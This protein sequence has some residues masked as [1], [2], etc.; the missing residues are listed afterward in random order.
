[1]CAHHLPSTRR[2]RIAFLIGML[3]MDAVRG[4]PED[5]SAFERERAADRQEIFHPLRSLVAAV[6]QQA[7]IAHAD[8]Q[9][10]G[11]PPQ[12][13][14]DEECLPGEE[15]QCGDRANVKCGHETRRNP[16][17][18]IFFRLSFFQILQFHIQG[19]PQFCRSLRR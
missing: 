5:R 9:A 7:V 2:V 10:A 12:E 8:A 18:F 13:H 1:M 17:H 6:R 11:N 4:D 19:R 14:R 3:M 16:V 15:E